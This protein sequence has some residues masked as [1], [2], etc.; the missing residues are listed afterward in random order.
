M[1]EQRTKW[2]GNGCEQRASG[3]TQEDWCTANGVNLY[4]LRDRASRL[5]KLDGREG[6][7]ITET[8]Q[9][10]KPLETATVVWMEVSPKRAL[11]ETA[12]INI[13]HSGF[14][15]TLRAGFD[16]ELLEAVLRAV[17]RACC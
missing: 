9:P 14:T 16:A 12:C 8:F 11:D 15:I 4:T 17:S 1:Q 10:P 3:Q 5:R 2:Q 6:S 7:V 13:T